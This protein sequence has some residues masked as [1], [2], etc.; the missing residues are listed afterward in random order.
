MKKNFD[1]WMI[2]SVVHGEEG[3]LGFNEEGCFEMFPFTHERALRFSSKELAE[4]FVRFAK[5]FVK[6]E[7][8]ICDHLFYNSEIDLQ[9]RWVDQ[10]DEQYTE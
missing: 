3:A 5:K 7:F 6:K 10:Y 2:E 4:G 8:K 9:Q 1:V